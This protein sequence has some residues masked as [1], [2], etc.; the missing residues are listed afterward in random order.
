MAK[1]YIVGFSDKLTYAQ[2]R[3]KAQARIIDARN[4]PLRYIGRRGSFESSALAAQEFT[5]AEAKKECKEYN[6]SP[7]LKGLKFVVIDE[8][9]KMIR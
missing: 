5:L 2:A 3:E 7:Y 8:Q 9:Y 4:P 1:Y 6:E